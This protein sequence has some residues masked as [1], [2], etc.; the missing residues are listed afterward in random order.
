VKCG[1]NAELNANENENYNWIYSLC[2]LPDGR[3]ATG[4]GAT[5][6]L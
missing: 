3:D 4:N 5:A 2:M 1:I 6:A